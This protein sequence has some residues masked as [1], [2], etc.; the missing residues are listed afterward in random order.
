VC[1]ANTQL[2]SKILVT[3]D[4]SSSS[5]VPSLT[6]SSINTSHPAC[7]SFTIRVCALYVIFFAS[8][9]SFRCGKADCHW[10]CCDSIHSRLPRLLHFRSWFEAC[11]SFSRARASGD[12]SSR[13]QPLHFGVLFLSLR[14]SFCVQIPWL[15]TS[16]STPFHHTII[17]CHASILQRAYHFRLSQRQSPSVPKVF[18][19]PGDR[20]VNS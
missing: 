13:S 14:I 15:A 11:W 2:A 3:M 18:I 9:G 5:M 20:A 17:F 1:C 12:I 8:L 6:R 16:V 4:L 10:L 7:F 19:A